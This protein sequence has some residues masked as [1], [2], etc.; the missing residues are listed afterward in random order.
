M[1]LSGSKKTSSLSSFINQ[2]SGGGPKKTGLPFQIGRTSAVS[3]SLK[4]AG[5]NY[6]FTK[7]MKRYL[8]HVLTYYTNEL[9]KK[10]ARR[11][12][13]SANVT[14][15]ITTANKIPD[16]TVVTTN[17]TYEVIKD[18]VKGMIT[19]L[20]V[21]EKENDVTAKK[22]ALD[23]VAEDVDNTAELNAYNTAV[24]EYTK[25]KTASDALNDI[26]VAIEQWAVKEDDVE[27]TSDAKDAAETKYN[28]A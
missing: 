1:V 2:N 15:K 4:N 5:Q 6:H 22:N 9:T 25:A 12:V 21:G 8:K 10:T 13:Y 28:E 24:T 19:G 18:E 26:I 27:A 3:I 14:A 23:N 7:G 11:D 17:K 16:V 20:K